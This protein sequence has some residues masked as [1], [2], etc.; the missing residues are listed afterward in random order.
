MDVQGTESDILVGAGK[1]LKT[2]K[3]VLLETQL[4][5]YNQ[6]VSFSHSIIAL[7]NSFGFRITDIYELHC[8]PDGRL[9]EIDILFAKSDDK[10]FVID[11]NGSAYNYKKYKIKGVKISDYFEIQLNSS[12]PVTLIKKLLKIIF[13]NMKK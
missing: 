10:I 1:T 3:Y 2:G 8:L 11:K 9:N 7:M 13:Y 12:P 4:V 6:S 5:E